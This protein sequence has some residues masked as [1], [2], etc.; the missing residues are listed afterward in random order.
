MIPMDHV[1][2][3]MRYETRLEKTA[4]ATRTAQK[5]KDDLRVPSLKR[6]LTTFLALFDQLRSFHR[7][8][9]ESADSHGKAT[10][11]SPPPL[12]FADGVESLTAKV[13]VESRGLWGIIFD[14]FLTDP[15]AT[16]AKS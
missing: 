4:V 14:I 16:D 15:R 2:W 6:S 13:R 5:R 9:G 10:A 11:A 8:L 3:S 7:C 1:V 12:I